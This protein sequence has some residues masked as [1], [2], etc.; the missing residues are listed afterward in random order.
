[1]IEK[2]TAVLNE[3]EPLAKLLY[4]LYDNRPTYEKS[5]KAHAKGK[6]LFKFVIYDKYGYYETFE[7]F[8]YK[9]RVILIHGCREH[10]WCCCGGSEIT[11]D[12]LHRIKAFLYMS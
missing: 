1:M 7:I 6:C 12:D 11:E 2:V 8:K 10:P 5:E 9:N 3:D 4:D